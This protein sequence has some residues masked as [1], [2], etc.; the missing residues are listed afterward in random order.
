[1]VVIHSQYRYSF[2]FSSILFSMMVEVSRQRWS[3]GK[4]RLEG[5]RMLFSVKHPECLSNDA[6]KPAI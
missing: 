4:E 1:V 6:A 2:L 3:F 5:R